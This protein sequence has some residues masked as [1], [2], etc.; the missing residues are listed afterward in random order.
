MKLFPSVFTIGED[1]DLERDRF[2]FQVEDGAYCHLRGTTAETVICRCSFLN[3]SYDPK[4]EKT[5]TE[6]GMQSDW[7]GR[8]S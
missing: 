6:V 1:N 2:L 3:A 8:V 5:F 4:L 7:G